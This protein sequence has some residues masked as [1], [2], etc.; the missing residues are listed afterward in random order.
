MMKTTTKTNVKLTKER[1]L[2]LIIAS[3]QG[4]LTARATLVECNLNLVRSIVRKYK[5]MGLPYEDLVNEGV[6]GLLKAI[7]SFDVTSGFRLSTHATY[8]IKQVSYRALENNG[9]TVRIPVYRLAQMG[10]VKKMEGQLSQQLGRLAT[11][12]EI[13]NA[14][15]LTVSDVRECK[16]L[17]TPTQSLDVQLGEDD[18]SGTML[19]TIEDENSSSFHYT[20]EQKELSMKVE[21]AISSL[22]ASDRDKQI[23]KLRFGIGS[24]WGEPMTLEAIGGRYSLTRERIR[25]IEVE[26]LKKLTASEKAEGLKTL[27]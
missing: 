24:A 13:A 27:Y 1:E 19:D 11:V 6:I 17:S 10:K 7:E 8:R 3:Q 23:L 12:E 16:K 22:K 9:R 26:M 21:E 14:L 20:L 5:D 4:D 18:N 2:Q 25:Q 15:D